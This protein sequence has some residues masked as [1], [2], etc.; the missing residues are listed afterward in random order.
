MKPGGKIIEEFVGLR[1]KLYSYKKL[2]GE[3][4]KKD[5][6]VKASVVKKTI[7]FDDYKRCLFNKEQQMRQMNVIRSHK[8]DVYTET[9]NK[10]ALSPFDDKRHICEDGIHTYAHG[11]Y[12]S[13]TKFG[14]SSVSSGTK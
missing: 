2:N 4:I 9:V 11:H 12:R 7:T 3:E 8:H 14:G 5:K 10:I 6:G 13:N 1:A